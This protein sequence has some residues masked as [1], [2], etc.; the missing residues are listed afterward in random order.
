VEAECAKEVQTT[1][2]EGI[3]KSS[4]AESEQSLLERVPKGCMRLDTWAGEL[5]GEMTLKQK[6]KEEESKSRK[7]SAL[8]RAEKHQDEGKKGSISERDFE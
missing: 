6:R 8:L 1:T 4:T 2:I 3:A 7:H 5:G